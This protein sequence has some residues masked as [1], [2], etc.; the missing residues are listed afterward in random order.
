VAVSGLDSAVVGGRA[1]YV[2][3]S[4]AGEHKPRSIGV[5][6][7]LGARSDS[8]IGPDDSLNLSATGPSDTGTR[9]EAQVRDLLISRLHAEGIAATSL[10]GARD[11]HGED[12][13]LE[14]EGRRLSLQVT[15]I[16][17]D[18]SYWKAAAGGTAYLSGTTKAAAKWLRDAIVGKSLIGGRSATVL[19]IDARHAGVVADSAVVDLYLA[20]FSSPVAE[21]GFA[22]VWVIGPT[23]SNCRRM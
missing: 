23:A 11:D 9:G 21:F 8:S 17:P 12:G 19:A 1:G 5:Q 15:S 16:P 13:I 14:I 2:N 7:P 3:E 10:P 4:P 6:T 22:Q 18:S 20:Q